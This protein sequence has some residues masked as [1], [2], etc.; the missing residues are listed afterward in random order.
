MRAQNQL[1][2][3]AWPSV[4]ICLNWWR[5]TLVLLPTCS[6]P[7]SIRKGIGHLSTGCWLFTKAF[8]MR[9][10]CGVNMRFAGSIFFLPFCFRFLSPS[11]PGCVDVTMYISLWVER[12]G[13]LNRITLEATRYVSNE[14]LKK[15]VMILIGLAHLCHFGACVFNCIFML[16]AIYVFSCVRWWERWYNL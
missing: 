9:S 12:T 13:H 6:S 11:F 8:T 4:Y 7:H 14:S 15:Y 5:D 2:S 3:S 16:M 10:V 1:F